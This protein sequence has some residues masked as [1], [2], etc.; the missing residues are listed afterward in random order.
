[1][2]RKHEY[3]AGLDLGSSRVR[4][5]VAVEEESRLRFV[6][7][8]EAAV[9]AGWEKGS[10]SDPEPVLA[11]VERAVAAAENNGALS[12]DSAVVGVGGPHVRANRSRAPLALNSWDNEIRREHMEEAMRLAA[13]NVLGEDRALLQN[14]PVEFS[15]DQQARVRNPIGMSG[16]RLDAVVQVVS[17]LAQAHDNVRAVVNRAGLVVEETISESFA[18]AYAV[19][20]EQERDMGVA[21]LDLGAGSVDIAV[22]QHDHLLYAGALPFGGGHCAWDVAHRFKTPVADAERLVEQYASVLPEQ[23]AANVMIETIGIDGGS[24]Q[25]PRR[26]LNETV[27]MRMQET[28]EKVREEL[29]RV[30]CGGNRLVGGLVLTGSLACLA[31]VC[32]LAE[33]VFDANVRIGLPPRIEDMPD[34]LDHPGWAVAIG[35]ALYA[36]RLRLQKNRRPE[37]V[38]DRLR[39]LFDGS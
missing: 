17:T 15:V 32:D 5:F 19:L 34:E 1:M 2:P 18:A 24:R 3:L 6:G 16:S 20:E 23:T 12:V 35:L 28:F 13:R 33:R 11:A 22:Y 26:L 38:A 30:G 7:S 21:L 27:A 4:C 29:N 37:T 31:G 14:V 10:I 25:Q 39:A 36:Q 9:A 8:G